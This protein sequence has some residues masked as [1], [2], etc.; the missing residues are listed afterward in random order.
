[1]ERWR[2]SE[3]SSPALF[4][5][6]PLAASILSSSRLYVLQRI[7]GGLWATRHRLDRRHGA[8][9]QCRVEIA[10]FRSLSQSALGRP[11]ALLCTKEAF[12]NFF[13][14]ILEH[15]APHYRRHRDWSLCGKA[16]TPFQREPMGAWRVGVTAGPPIPYPVLGRS[17]RA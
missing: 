9:R 6:L 1:M 12:A 2:A 7:R 13:T 14:E 16:E 5:I 4:P 17:H 10:R 8:A 3:R 15:S 11:L